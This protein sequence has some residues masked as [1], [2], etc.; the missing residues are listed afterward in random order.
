MFKP[1]ANHN[2]MLLVCALALAVVLAVAGASILTAVTTAMVFGIAAIGLSILGGPLKIV[3]IG[4]SAF[5]GVGAFTTAYFNNVARL[6]L[7]L[8]LLLSAG[9]CMA[10][11]L[12][13]APIA[14]RL[15]GIYMAI[16]TVGLA[17]LAQHIFRIATPWTGGTAGV[18][19]RSVSLFGLELMRPLRIGVVTL[20]S[21]QLF[22]IVTAVVLLLVAWSAVNILQS[23]TGRAW[24]TIGES[25]LMARSFG[26]HPELYRSVAIIYSSALAGLAGGLL[27]VTTSYVSWEQFDLLMSVNLLAVAVLGGLGSV[28]AVVVATTI[29]YVLP[30]IVDLFAEWIPF[31]SQGPSSDGLSPEQLTSVI[32]GFALVLVMIVEPGG[33][34]GLVRRATRALARHQ[35][36]PE[37]T[38]Q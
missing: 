31:V 19:L 29:L 10:V 11:G 27:A 18:Q 4:A 12:I 28:Y 21:T 1:I 16:I 15:T 22:F 17:F 3:N 13:V 35:T 34:A 14:S 20:S 32:Y 33:F 26:I 7:S 6:D 30:K 24:R 36:V 38:M 8:S 23:R 9:A 5:I 2:G 25:P 37:R